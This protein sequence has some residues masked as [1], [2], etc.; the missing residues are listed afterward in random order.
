MLC[1]HMMEGYKLF[2]LIPY[3]LGYQSQGSFPNKYQQE[4]TVLLVFE[5]TNQCTLR[6][7]GVALSIIHAA[8]EVSGTE[9]QL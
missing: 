9:I 1:N 4:L 7:R 8:S 6:I 2:F 3:W 5:G